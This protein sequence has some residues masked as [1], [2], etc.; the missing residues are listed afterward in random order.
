MSQRRPFFRRFSLRT[1]L[2]FAFL[3]VGMVGMGLLALIYIRTTRE[4]LIG[5]ANQT[6]YAAASRTATSLDTF[7]QT[8]LEN[9]RIESSLPSLRA[10]MELPPE[11]RSGSEAE[12]IAAQT[13]EN[14]RNKDLFHIS[15]YALLDRDG[16]NLLDTNMTNT[17][18][19]ESEADYFLKPLHNGLPFVSAVEF[20]PKVGGVYFYFSSPV[21]NQFGQIVGVLRSR[22][23]V[24][25]LQKMVSESQ[26]LAGDGSFAIL[27]DDYGMRLA[28]D[29]DPTLIFKSLVP[30]E[31]AQHAEL[32]AA[33][34][35]PN[36]SEP[37]MAT[38]RQAFAEGLTQAEVS[39]FFTAAEHSGEHLE[40]VAVVHL[41]TQPWQVAYVLAR[42]EFLSPINNA[43][44]ITVLWT[45]VFAIFI[46]A[47]AVLVSR[48]LTRPVL[49]LTA[50]T[51]R[52]SAGDLSAQAEVSADDET[53]RL[54]IAFNN[55]TS[56]LRRTLEGLEAREEALQKSNEQLEAALIE[57]QETQAQ[58]VQQERIAAVGQLAAG[59]AHDFNNIMA[60]VILYSDLLLKTGDLAKKEEK[61]IKLIREQGQRA[62]DLTQQILD[63]SRKSIMQRQDLDFWYFL[64]D[65]RSLLVRTL[66]ENIRFNMISKGDHFMINADPTRIQ[67]VVLN[68]VLNAR[69]AMPDGGELCVK[70]SDVPQEIDALPLEI[71]TGD[72]VC[73]AI[74]DTGKG[75][76]D[77][78]LARIFEPFFTTRAPMGSG[79]GLSQV[80]GIIKQHG[81]RIDVKTAVGEGTTFLVYL[82]ILPDERSET[83]VS[84]P[85]NLTSGH[86]ETILLV[87][88]DALIRDAL[89]HSLHSL[90]YQVLCA[91][92]GRSALR[93]HQENRDKIDLVVS[94]LVMPEMGGKALLE[95]LKRK[96]PSLKTVIITGYPLAEQESDLQTLGVVDWCQKPVNLEELSQVIAKALKTR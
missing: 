80:D 38:N 63:F 29:R 68:L 90:N 1:Q 59:I 95:A 27:F 78:V 21:H 20:A 75:I 55:M 71:E 16:V 44:Q 70:L 81:G 60:T 24:A 35:L 94:D 82:P 88:D 17:G 79:L 48:W 46:V 54:A 66:P 23:S 74:S 65:M 64:V 57:L 89:S 49:E 83:T 37:E 84:Y 91:E 5:E 8:N 14:L 77:E 22:Y 87:E 4:A 2:I 85:E 19:N 9:M 7:I 86:G 6:L 69:N 31:P 12:G 30:L 58:M 10:Y 15:S 41:D 36:L 92:N 3:L 56:Q 32:Q 72:W 43:I 11:E 93:I 45:A 61:R 25:V 67:Q 51:E 18:L 52:I 40:Q 73:L 26:E 96:D 13:L 50:V 39:P 33:H 34:R 47:S 62:A 76:S 53:G 42:D 28:H